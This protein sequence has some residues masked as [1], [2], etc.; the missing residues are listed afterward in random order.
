MAALHRATR[1]RH[2]VE[3]ALRLGGEPLL[4]FGLRLSCGRRLLGR[5]LRAQ[6]ALE[7]VA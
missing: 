1:V 4:L 6:T 5:R 3:R 7:A 2:L